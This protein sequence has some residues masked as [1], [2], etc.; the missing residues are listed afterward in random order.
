MVQIVT[1]VMLSRK[2]YMGRE[3]VHTM[4]LRHS[5]SAEK[6]RIHTYIQSKRVVPGMEV[7]LAQIGHLALLLPE[8]LR[9]NAARLSDWHAVD[10]S[11][12]LSASLFF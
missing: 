9:M 8:P 6:T 2:F 5:S 12:R 4:A 7:W 10:D 11:V 3:L 1:D